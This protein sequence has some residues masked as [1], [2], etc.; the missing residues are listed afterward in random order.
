VDILF[1]QFLDMRKRGHANEV[2]YLKN[3]ALVALNLAEAILTDKHDGFSDNAR[4][5]LDLASHICANF[6][7]R[8]TPW[9]RHGSVRCSGRRALFGIG[10]S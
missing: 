2:D 7:R 3:Q 9:R 4:A 10:N 5:G 1:D 6:H 8:Q